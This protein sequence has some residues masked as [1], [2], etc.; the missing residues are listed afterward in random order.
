MYKRQGQEQILQLTQVAKGASI[1][2]GRNLGDSL[3]RIFR[4]AIKL[5][6]ELLDEIGLF[7]RVDE[8][9]SKYARTLGKSVT[10]LTQYEK[11]QAFLNG[12]IEQGTKKFQDF[13]DQVDPDPYTKLAAALGD[14]AQNVTSFV[15]KALGPLV[16]FLADSRGLLFAVFAGIATILIKQAVPAISQFTRNLEMSAQTTLEDRDIFIKSQEAKVA[17]AKKASLALKDT[18]I[19][20]QKD[21]AKSART[22]T[23]PKDRFVS[24][25][26]GA[27]DPK[28]LNKELS[29]LDRQRV[30]QK[31]ILDLEKSQAKVKGKNA[32]LVKNEL[33]DLRAEERQL[34]K[35]VLLEEQRAKIKA[36]PARAGKGTIADIENQKSLNAAIV[37]GGTASVLTTAQTQGLK[38]GF[39]E[40]FGSLSSGEVQVDGQTKKIKGLQKGTFALKG[41]IG[42][43][44]ASFSRFLMILGPIGIGL[45]LIAPFLPAIARAT[46]LVTEES[47]KLTKTFKQ[48]DEQQKALANR[49]DIQTTAIKNTELSYVETRKAVLAYNTTNLET[50]KLINQSSKDLAAFQ[51][52]LSGLGASWEGFKSIFGLDRESK[53]IKSQ[54]ESIKDSIEAAILV[55]D[56]GMLDIFKDLS[57]I[58]I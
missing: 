4:G 45:S 10:S 52:N 25:A 40:F 31:R 17:A 21:I 47:S 13:A 38:A 35:V 6:P 22:A 32:E 42:L 33:N 50:F 18:E 20:S 16:S 58:H 39:S 51:R 2:L 3:D 24:K 41:G 49:F 26:K 19:K 5:E 8:E 46:G 7:V 43:L 55:D 12:V 48:L 53:V 56:Q 30:V 54:T 1:A 57:L 11:R 23:D 15:N 34:K 37:A 27:L 44:G 36:S 29:A 14:I 9:S 28:V